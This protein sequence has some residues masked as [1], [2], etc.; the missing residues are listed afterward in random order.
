M[1]KEVSLVIIMSVLASQHEEL[2]EQSRVLQ[3]HHV[4][5]S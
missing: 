1:E 3:G 5:A 4:Q 2:R